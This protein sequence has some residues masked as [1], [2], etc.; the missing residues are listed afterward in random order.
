MNPLKGVFT[1]CVVVATTM[2]VHSPHAPGD[3]GAV[4]ADDDVGEA[5]G[6]SDEALD[7]SS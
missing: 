6:A 1:N 5:V 4:G 7:A 2:I 3:G